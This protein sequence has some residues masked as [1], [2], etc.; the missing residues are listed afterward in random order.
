MAISWEEKMLLLK[1]TLFFSA[2]FPCFEVVER[3]LAVLS[4]AV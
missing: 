1:S 3:V 4:A 2:P